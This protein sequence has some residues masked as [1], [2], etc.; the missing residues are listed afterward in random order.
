VAP[1]ADARMLTASS[2]SPARLRAWLALLPVR[3]DD[4]RFV[5]R[6]CLGLLLRWIALSFDWWAL[7]GAL[8]RAVV[9]TLR[10]LRIA[11]DARDG[12]RF[13]IGAQLVDVTVPCTHIEVFALVAPLLWDRRRTGAENLVR[14]GGVGVAVLALALVRID[15]AVVLLRAGVPWVVGHDVVLGVGY[16]ALLA[17][18][19][20]AGAWTREAA[21]A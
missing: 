9:S 4:R 19:L 13:A 16:F 6:A 3:V 21:R 20:K 12:A 17:L 2:A 5:I 15:L 1:A 8:A 18:T 11:I 7:R 14:L 10:P